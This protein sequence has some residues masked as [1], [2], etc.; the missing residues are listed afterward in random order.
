MAAARRVAGTLRVLASVEFPTS[1]SAGAWAPQSTPYRTLGTLR[2]GSGWQRCMYA[3]KPMMHLDACTQ[4]TYIVLMRICPVAPVSSVSHVSRPAVPLVTSFRSVRSRGAR[5]GVSGSRHSGETADGSSSDLYGYCACVRQ[6]AYT[7]TPDHSLLSADSHAVRVIHSVTVS[8]T[9]VSVSR[10][11][12]IDRYTPVR[13][14]CAAR[15]EC[16]VTVTV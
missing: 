2:P 5:T 7:Q 9:A 4:H 3:G 6:P 1:A 16:R 10:N 15:G 8:P 11:P 14:S 12:R 13:Y